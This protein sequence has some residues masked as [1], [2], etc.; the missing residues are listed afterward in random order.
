MSD[1]DVR[2]KL[3]KSKDEY[4]DFYDEI[5]ELINSDEAINKVFAGREDRLLSARMLS[6]LYDGDKLIG[7][8][9]LVKEKQNPRFLFLDVGI[10]EEYRGRHIAS[11]VSE[12]LKKISKFI[13]VETR[14]NN[15]LANNSLRNKTAFLF[16]QGNRNVYLLQKDRLEEFMDK[17]YY[18]M[19][20][21]HYTINS[22]RDLIK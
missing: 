2:V 4:C 20:S 18:E 5:T 14:Q 13:I 22:K 3:C 1:I 21:N 12:D 10:I 11:Y 7:F 6:T 16:E 9:N 19:L 15:V 8:A 17:G